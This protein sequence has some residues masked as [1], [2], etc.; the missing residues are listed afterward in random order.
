[1]V[2]VMGVEPT[3]PK[4]QEPKSWMSTYFT[5]PRYSQP[6]L[7]WSWKTSQAFTGCPIY[8]GDSCAREYDPLEQVMGIEPMFSA[9]KADTLTIVLHLQMV[10][11]L[12]LE[13]RAIQ[14]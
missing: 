14:L 11:L 12:G 8:L 13:P 3:R 7:H 2:W 6:E 5:I 9:W 4:P 10:G 1:M